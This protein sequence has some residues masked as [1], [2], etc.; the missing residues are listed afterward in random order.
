LTRS[1]VLACPPRGAPGRD[2][3]HAVT[4]AALRGQVVALAAL[5]LARDHALAALDPRARS[6]LDRS[7]PARRYAA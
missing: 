4:T 6:S 1:A 5:D 3:A 7:A 2:E